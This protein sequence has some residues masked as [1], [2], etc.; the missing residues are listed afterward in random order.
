MLNGFIK[1]PND[2]LKPKIQYYTK[3]TTYCLSNA[4]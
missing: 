1:Q 3:Y 4:Y 2:A